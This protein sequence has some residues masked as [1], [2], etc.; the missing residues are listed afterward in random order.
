MAELLVRLGI[1]V[2]SGIAAGAA[3]SG[4]GN[5][6]VRNSSFVIKADQDSKALHKRDLKKKE[7][8][9]RLIRNPYIL[10]VR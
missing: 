5:G 4:V 3:A 8:A 7:K 6:N 9:G 1:G 10:W 2:A